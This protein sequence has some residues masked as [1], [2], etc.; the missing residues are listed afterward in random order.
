MLGSATVLLGGVTNLSF[1]CEVRWEGERF[2][3][4]FDSNDQSILLMKTG[5]AIIFLV[6]SIPIV[7][8]V[9]VSFRAGWQVI[10]SIKK[11]KRYENANA[12]YRECE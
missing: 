8:T 1:G 12:G 5:R 6:G 10:G 4:I 7:F 3:I 2:W 11:P 9:D